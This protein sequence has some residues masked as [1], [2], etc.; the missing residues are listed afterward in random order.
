MNILN[1]I[2]F[3]MVIYNKQLKDVDSLSKIFPYKGRGKYKIITIDNSDWKSILE[4]NKMNSNNYLNITY[5][6]SGG[7]IGLSAAYNKALHIIKGNQDNF[8]SYVCWLDD[9]T[10]IDDEFLD[11]LFIEI[12]KGY[13][14]IVPKVKARDGFIYSPNERGKLRNNFVLNKGKKIRKNKFN[15]INSCLTVKSKIYKSFKYD[16]NLFLDQV[17]QLFFD[18][19]NY[20]NLKFK[21]L[22]AVVFQNFSQMNN[23][24]D[25]KYTKRFEI[26]TKDILEYG[27]ISPKNNVFLGMIKVLLLGFLFSW[28]SSNNIYLKISFKALKN[29]FFSRKDRL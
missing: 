20:E 14:V 21:I 24:T 3:V 1:M 28:K 16:E 2:Y 8:N 9:D 27:R 22:D 23:F 25:N 7:N 15:A 19:L 17:D 18:S 26:R 5:I 10:Q 6:A 12:R 29:F 11:N 13:D 4:V